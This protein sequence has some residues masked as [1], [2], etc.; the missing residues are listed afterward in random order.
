[1]PILT[2]ADVPDL[3]LGARTSG[4]GSSQTKKES[5]EGGSWADALA[6]F[7][8][9]AAA[10]ETAR[11]EMRRQV[12]A[13]EESFFELGDEAN[14][15]AFG[16][17]DAEDWDDDDDDEL[18]ARADD[19]E[20]E[21]DDGISDLEMRYRQ[22]QA[23]GAV[24]FDLGEE[25]DDGWEDDA[26]RERGV[27]SEMRCFDTAKIYIKAGDGGRGMVA[28]RREAFVAQGGPYG[29]NGGDGGAIYFEADESINSLVGFR[30]KVHHRAEPGGAGGGKRMQGR[31]GADKTVYVPPGTVIR[32]SKTG[33]ILAEMFAH[34]HREMVLPGGR[35]GRG[36]ASF[37]TALNKAPQIAENGEEGQE[38]WVEMELKLV[39]DVGIIGVPNAGKS[40]LLSNISNAKPKIADYPFTTIVPN[41]G[42][43][44]R[45]FER[46]VFADIPGLLEGASE[47]IGLGFEFLRHVKRTRVLVHVL[48]CTS[49]NVLEE[50]DAIRNE[51]FLFD[52]EVGDKPELVA[53]N[54]V[55][56]SDEAAER[57]L[58]LQELF[59]KERGIDAHVISAYEGQG[60]A[61]LVDAVKEVWAALPAPDYEAQAEAAAAR[62][63]ARPA[64]GKALDDFTIVDTPYAFVVEGAAIE[65]F[66]Q[67]TNWDYFESFKRF[68]RVLQMSG[69]ERAINEAGAGEGDRIV[70]GKY[71]F[72]WSGDKREK[73]LFDSWKAKQ[74]EKPAGTTRQGTR[75]WPH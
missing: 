14:F 1:M 3:R 60:T 26:P 48:D 50:Y 6:D 16:Q 34:G 58:R 15:V 10:K 21:D 41:L 11:N 53:L 52:E 30:K 40:T 17:G 8:S 65:R 71:E 22:G 51:L 47:G 68:A 59:V 44:E 23:R 69:V 9:D 28:F 20:W 62:R 4:G 43:V 29:G 38:R 67:M 49:E 36:N 61:Q 27:P 66:V 12:L 2:P 70:I 24:E 5:S 32:D 7:R 37:K 33:E 56:V 74:D 35:G 31:I 73:A 72:E 55:D 39:A 57:A 75:H 54:K 19:D 63:V 13:E 25:L 42:V 45:D 64:D 46:M 18:A